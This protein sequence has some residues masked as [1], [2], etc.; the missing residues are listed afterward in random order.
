MAWE[1]QVRRGVVDRGFW[2]VDHV[3]EACSRSL[4]TKP[5]C[6]N[7]MHEQIPPHNDRGP[8]LDN[9]ALVLSSAVQ[10]RWARSSKLEV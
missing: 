3:H 7:R 9:R 5:D 2:T 4:F 8:R 6:Q 10:L 1:P